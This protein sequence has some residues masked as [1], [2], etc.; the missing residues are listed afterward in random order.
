VVQRDILDETLSYV[1]VYRIRGYVCVRENRAR[2]RVG[3]KRRSLYLSAP[4][5]VCTE[6][7][8]PEPPPQLPISPVWPFTATYVFRH[9]LSERIQPSLSQIKNAR[10]ARMLTS[11]PTFAWLRGWRSREA[12]GSNFTSYTVY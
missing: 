12:E 11:L 8:C 5:A 2:G 6:C 3:R 4:E 9:V 10:M 1:Y 7:S